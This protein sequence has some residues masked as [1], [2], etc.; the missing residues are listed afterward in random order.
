MKEEEINSSDNLESSL[1]LYT[2]TRGSMETVQDGTEC[3]LT[4]NDPPENCTHSEMITELPLCAKKSQRDH[5]GMKVCPPEGP[6]L[7]P[8]PPLRGRETES[9]CVRAEGQWW[10]VNRGGFPIPE[11][12]WEKMWQHVIDTHPNGAAIAESIRERPCRRVSYICV[13]GDAHT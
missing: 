6:G 13:W 8:C 4:I 3:N 5:H 2:A 7:D 12:T 10:H 9:Q 1:V 11:A